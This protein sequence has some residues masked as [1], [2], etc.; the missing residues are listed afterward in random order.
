MSEALPIIMVALASVIVPISYIAIFEPVWFPPAYWRFSHR[1]GC[2]RQEFK[3]LRREALSSSRILTLLGHIVEVV[4][5]DV[6]AACPKC[7]RIHRFTVR[8]ANPIL[9]HDDE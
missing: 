7:G 9:Q 5:W 6:R 2:G 8:T 1:N 3:T 4:E